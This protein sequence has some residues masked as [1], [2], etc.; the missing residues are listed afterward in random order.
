MAIKLLIWLRTG[1]LRRD[2]WHWRRRESLQEWVVSLLLVLRAVAS[3]MVWEKLLWLLRLRKLK[4]LKGLVQGRV[5]CCGRL[6]RQERI[7]R[8]SGR[9][10]LQTLVLLLGSCRRRIQSIER[11]H[12]AYT[13]RCCWRRGRR[14]APADRQSV[15]AFA[16]GRYRGMCSRE[17]SSSFSKSNQSLHGSLQIPIEAFENRHVAFFIRKAHVFQSLKLC[18]KTVGGGAAHIV[19]KYS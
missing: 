18:L 19:S 17:A 2:L 5:C 8:C 3:R 14:S 7:V 11:I 15:R 13:S 12:R 10:S 1:E 16:V 6:G 9:L 4:V